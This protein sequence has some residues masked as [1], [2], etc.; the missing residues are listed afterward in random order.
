MTII[1]KED[2]HR[3]HLAEIFIQKNK[4]IDYI[5]QSA[6]NLVISNAK[7]G[8]SK[9]VYSQSNSNLNL[10]NDDYV[11]ESILSGLQNI[12]IDSE[13]TVYLEGFDSSTIV[14]NVDWE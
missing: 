4:H 9:M 1:T 7:C 13:I 10:K 6:K 3:M 14:V 8:K 5:I 11:K 12:F 2:L